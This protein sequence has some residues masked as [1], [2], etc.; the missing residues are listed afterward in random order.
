MRPLLHYHGIFQQKGFAKPQAFSNLLR[1][2]QKFSTI[3][4]DQSKRTL[5]ANLAQRT[6]SPYPIHSSEWPSYAPGRLCD[7][8]PWPRAAG[9][10]ERGRSCAPRSPQLVVAVDGKNLPHAAPRVVVW[11]AFVAWPSFSRFSHRRRVLRRSR[12]ASRQ[13][14]EGSHPPPQWRALAGTEPKSHCL[15]TRR[16]TGR[17]GRA[18]AAASSRLCVFWLTDRGGG[19]GAGRRWLG[20]G[21]LAASSHRTGARD[22]REPARR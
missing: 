13:A 18:P 12:L 6:R 21:L 20:G 8:Q 3:S 17:P 19:G 22:G 14:W 2:P 10:C 5:N 4:C 16:G 15:V 1:N 7:T 11:C 9:L